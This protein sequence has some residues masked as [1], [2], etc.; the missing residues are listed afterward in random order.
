[1]TETN[2]ILRPETFVSG[3]VFTRLELAAYLRLNPRTLAN[4][5]ALGTGPTQIGTGRNLFYAIEDVASWLMQLKIGAK[6]RARKH[7]H[8]VESTTPLLP[9]RLYTRSEAAQSINRS[10]Q[11]LANW[12]STGKLLA[13]YSL[14]LAPRYTDESLSPWM[15]AELEVAA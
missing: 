6:V 9:P 13:T 15:T 4:W 3:Q 5:T 10:A 2:L 12:A 7:L 1:M 14:P 11:T 8:V